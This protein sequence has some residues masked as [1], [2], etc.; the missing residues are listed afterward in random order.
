MKERVGIIKPNYNSQISVDE[1]HQFIIANDVTNQCNDSHQLVPMTKLSEKVLGEKPKSVKADNGYF[2]QLDEMIK[3]FPEID[4]YL[5]DVNRRKEYVDLDN[6]SKKY[7]ENQ[8]NNLIKLLKKKGRIE[9]KKRMHTAEPPFGNIKH[10]MGYRYFLLRG[11]H[12]VK[13][14]FN[15]MCIAH[16]IK[17]IYSFITKYIGDIAIA[18]EYKKIMKIS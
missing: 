11:L 8:L 6:L 15:L 14:E 12:K 1:K 2:P 5:D 7:S 16:N 4:L 10:N 9:Y 18:L 13:G 3:Q 17:K